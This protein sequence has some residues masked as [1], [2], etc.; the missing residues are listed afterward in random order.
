[1]STPRS[2]RCSFLKSALIE[3]ERLK[4]LNDAPERQGDYV[5]Y[6]MQ[7]SQR[8]AFNPA[9]EA[10]IGCANRL[11][12][13]VVVCFG[14]TDGYPGANARHYSFMLQGLRDVHEALAARGIAF[15]MRRGSPDEVAIDEA[16]T[17]AK[18]YCGADAP[19]FVNGILGAVLRE[20]EAEA[21]VE[22]A[23]GDIEAAAHRAYER[24]LAKASGKL[25]G[26]GSVTR[27]TAV[28]IVIGGAIGVAT[29][30]IAGPLGIVV[31]TGAGAV[32]STI[33]DVRN[34]LRQRQ[35]RGWV[36]VHHRITGDQ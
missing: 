33:A 15:V 24:H 27:R 20:V 22:V 14:L 10:A 19:G 18:R 26:V 25:E 23:R 13:P 2:A 36:T 32:M 8:E 28:G 30:P 5:V 11:N 1:M 17:L 16:V 6:W 4:E 7:Q 21:G 9:L 3:A 29:S 12:L 31:S 35:S 34:M